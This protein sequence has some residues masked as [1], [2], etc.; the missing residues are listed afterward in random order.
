MNRPSPRPDDSWESDPIW[1]LLDASPAPRASER[2]A[3]R[4]VRAARLAGCGEPPWWRKLLS[5]APLGGLAAATAAVVFAAMA[6]TGPSGDPEGDVA[7]LGEGS[8]ENFAAIQE[9]AE[10]EAL[11]AAVDQLEDFSDREL[12]HLIGL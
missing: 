3:E 10:A 4:T 7:E 12:V 11:M 5:P 8:S 1:K 2:F 6:L 9:A